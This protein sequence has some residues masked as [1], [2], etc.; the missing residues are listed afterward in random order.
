MSLKDNL[1]KNFPIL[2]RLME[3]SRASAQDTDADLDAPSGID[4]KPDGGRMAILLNKKPLGIAIGVLVIAVIAGWIGL[5]SA[6]MHHKAG[7]TA[8]PGTGPGGENVV[9]ARASAVSLPTP[10]EPATKPLAAPTASNNGLPPTPGTAPATAAGNVQG[11][12]GNAQP[13]EPQQNGQPA[14]PPQPSP[15]QQATIAALSGGNSSGT[16]GWGGAQAAKP[17][18]STGLSFPPNVTPQLPTPALPSSLPTA[19][20]SPNDQSGLGVYD[21]HLLRRPASPYEVM[22]GSVIPATLTTGIESDLPGQITGI[23]SRNVFDSA[24]GASLLIPGG[25]QIVGTYVPRVLPGQSSV[26]VAWNRI[27]FPNGSYVN[28]GTMPGTDPNGMSGLSGAVDNHTWLMFKNALL[29]S[30]ISTGMAEAQ[31]AQ[32]YN[33]VMTTQQ[34]FTQQFSQTFGQAVSQQLQKYATI[35]PTIHVQP[36]AQLAIVVSKDIVFPGPYTDAL[37][38]DPARPRSWAPPSMMNPYPKKGKGG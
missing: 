37:A 7:M 4:I 31:P 23:V 26:A 28:L 34:L 17:V 9:L 14:Q 32:S 13:G 3:R 27:I 29:V 10:P 11:A 16:N 5:R 8:G 19:V 35:A 2:A 1:Y 6:G 15:Q 21:T 24:S 20:S 30:L 22:Q 25:S 33:G 18:Q 38:A 12:N 36:G